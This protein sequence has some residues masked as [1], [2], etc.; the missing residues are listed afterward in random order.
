MPFNLTRRRY[1]MLWQMLFLIAGTSWLWAS[2]LNPALSYR[3]SLI[4]QYEVPNEPYSWLFRVSDLLAGC[5]LLLMAL[6]ILKSRSKVAAGWL[7]LAIS[8]GLVLDPLLTTTCRDTGSACQEYFS[9]GFIL[10]A[11]ETILTAAVFF[12]IALY[13]SWLRKKLVSIIFAVFQAGY[14]VLFISQLANH[15][16][17]NTVSQYMYQTALI[18]WLAWFCRDFLVGDNLGTRTK[19]PVVVKSFTAGWAFINGILAII[20]S[21]A[22]LHLV[23]RIKGLYFTGDSAWLAQHGVIIGV[24][25]L[26]LSRHLARGERRARQIFL[27][28]I[29]LEAIKYSVISP[30]AILM[31]FYSLTFVALFIF[32]DDFNRGVIAL[33][34]RVR[35]KDLFYMVSGLLLA[36]AAALMALDSDSR[37]SVITSRSIDNFFDYVARNDTSASSHI[38]SALL[39]H[40]ISAFLLAS[41]GSILW[42]LFRPYK[43][44][45]GQ[46][47]YDAMAEQTLKR[48]SSSSEDFFKLWPPDK[49]YF[50]NQ[51]RSG[52]VAYKIAGPTAF[53][54]A[55]PI[56]SHKPELLA[57]F[58]QWCRQRRLKVCFIPVYETSKNLYQAAGLENIQV[59]SSAIIDIRKFLN[60]TAKE[61]WWRWQINRG[62]KSG[63]IYMQSLP[64]HPRAFMRQLKGVSNKW[65]SRGGRRERG[66]ALGYFNED[67]L[68]KCPIH[69]LVNEKNKIVAFTNEVPRFHKSKTMTIDLLRY[70]PEANNSMPYLLYKMLESKSGCELFDLGFV[71]F[72]RAKGPLLAIAK[73]FSAGR[74][75]ARGLEQ[76]K[77]KFD[78]DWQPNYLAY[79]G[80]LADLVIIALNI[81]NAM[82]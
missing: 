44:G 45:H 16:H 20:L 49:S 63:Y 69:Y 78:P 56:G 29:G 53:A 66:F 19:E 42:I 15:D 54:L 28:I 58:N 65:L 70:R 3:T 2:R 22:H 76:F 61:K 80:D 50:W 57:E 51:D 75:S 12:V 60:Q 21:L 41:L 39:A 37:A 6:F 79:E 24:I 72:A 55:D 30:N 40:S 46:G 26:Y 34:W 62:Q 81:E 8:I 23:G 25:M 73:T 7:L 33:T 82:E 13:D 52:F 67:Y 48:C 31:L 9:F 38:S 10:H 1:M 5:L 68:Q 43:I 17:F 11:T 59:G 35:L 14:G 36:V 18:V 4:S 32:R 64:P 74:F 47:K 27:F 71:P 77:N